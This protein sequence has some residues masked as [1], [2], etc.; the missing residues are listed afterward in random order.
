MNNTFFPKEVYKAETNSR[1]I[2]V[3]IEDR[4]NEVELEDYSE[5]LRMVFYVSRY[6]SH[7]K[8]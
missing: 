7:D 8:N 5:P 1:Y 2:I 4:Q 6:H 3:S